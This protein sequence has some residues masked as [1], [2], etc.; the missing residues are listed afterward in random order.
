MELNLQVD[1]LIMLPVFK[2]TLEVSFR[3]NYIVAHE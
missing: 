1:K 2:T 3:N